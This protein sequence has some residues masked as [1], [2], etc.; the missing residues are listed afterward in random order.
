MPGDVSLLYCERSAAP[1]HGARPPR[2]GDRLTQLARRPAAIDRHDVFGNV[3][4]SVR[5]EKDYDLRDL[6][7]VAPTT[8]RNYAPALSISPITALAPSRL[9]A[10]AVARPIP[11]A[12]PVTTT[13]LSAVRCAPT[14]SRREFCAHLG[15]P[16]RKGASAH[17]GLASPIPPRAAHARRGAP[18]R[19][20]FCQAAAAAARAGSVDH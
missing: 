2:R 13:T 18:H 6:L 17:P 12:P 5:A 1:S 11:D 20:S 8:E 19:R 4:G 16:D 9:K 10:T 7:R 15:R 3:R 14:T